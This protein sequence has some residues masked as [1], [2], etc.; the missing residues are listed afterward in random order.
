MGGRW[1]EEV[2]GMGWLMVLAMS[3][4]GQEMMNYEKVNE[5]RGKRALSPDWLH[6]RSLLSAGAARLGPGCT[7]FYDMSCCGAS[8][9][10]Y[11]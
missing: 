3:W 10:I 4:T 5:T 11:I 7:S 9:L 8:L 2:D 6:T 1:A